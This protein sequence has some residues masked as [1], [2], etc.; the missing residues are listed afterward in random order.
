MILDENADFTQMGP[1]N[2]QVCLT[3]SNYVLK[4]A[5]VNLSVK[6]TG[7]RVA[8]SIL[9]N[10]TEVQMIDLVRLTV[11]MLKTNYISPSLGV[12]LKKLIRR[13]S[14]IEIA[15]LLQPLFEYQPVPRKVL[16]NELFS[17]DEPLFCPVWFSTQ[18]WMLLFDEDLALLARKINN[19]F[20]ITLRSEVFELKLEKESKNLF[21]FV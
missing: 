19:K 16:M 7:L 1:G 18:I 12:F 13:T 4:D 20:G 10:N 5:A 8:S 6:E 14:K 17:Y 2:L 15:L 21:L 9:E 11:N 3:V